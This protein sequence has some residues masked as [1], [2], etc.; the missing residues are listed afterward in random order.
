MFKFTNINK[1]LN[2]RSS[3]KEL[4]FVNNKN[5]L[6][7]LFP[8]AIMNFSTQQVAQKDSGAAAKPKEEELKPEPFIPLEKMPIN[9]IIETK[10]KGLKETYYY[11]GSEKAKLAE[12][13]YN[14]I[15]FYSKKLRRDYIRAG[16]LDS[17]KH[18]IPVKRLRTK[19]DTI[20]SLRKSREMAAVIE[21]REE[22][23]DV[24]IVIDRRFVDKLQM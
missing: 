12:K 3:L 19:A 22:F 4:N 5:N 18:V 7:R 2:L 10:R 6:L 15:E 21:G 14:V 8:S 16:E 17:H 23:P 24:N 13:K 11:F 20:E 1:F 9:K